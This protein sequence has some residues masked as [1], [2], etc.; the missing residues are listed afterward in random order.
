L[1]I[2]SLFTRQALS[3]SPP[4]HA[5]QTRHKKNLLALLLI[6]LIVAGL[7]VYT[8]V[9]FGLWRP[10]EYEQYI[11]LPSSLP[12]AHA[13]WHRQ[14]HAGDH[15]EQIIKQW[16]PHQIDRFGPWVQLYWFP[17]GPSKEFISFIGINAVAKDGVLV[18]AFFSR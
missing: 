8:G 5:R 3:S 6:A 11:A 16:Q 7:W 15:I 1:K 2:P 18:H 14:I 10:L 13:L 9:R 12:V 17:G 4:T